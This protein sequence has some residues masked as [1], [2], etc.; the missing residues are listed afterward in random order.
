MHACTVHIVL[1]LT[2]TLLSK[3]ARLVVSVLA[4]VRGPARLCARPSPGPVRSSQP[5]PAELRCCHQHHRRE[6]WRDMVGGAAAAQSLTTTHYFRYHESDK[7]MTVTTVQWTPR[8]TPTPGGW[9]PRAG[10]GSEMWPSLMCCCLC[11]SCFQ[12]RLQDKMFN[13]FMTYSNNPRS[14][15]CGEAGD[16]GLWLPLKLSGN[17]VSQLMVGLSQVFG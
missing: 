2:L 5:S 6:R 16:G 4:G 8:P 9:K 14:F 12:D 10:P 1:H 17:L 11:S 15:S 3:E 7:T 13:H